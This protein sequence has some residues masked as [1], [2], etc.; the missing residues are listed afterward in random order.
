[1]TFMH[2]TALPL[3][4]RSSSYTVRRISDWVRRREALGNVRIAMAEQQVEPQAP[5]VEQKDIYMTPDKYAGYLRNRFRTRIQHQHLKEHFDDAVGFRFNALVLGVDKSIK[6]Q[7]EEG[8]ESPTWP[9]NQ[10][11]FIPLKKAGLFVTIPA[12]EESNV[13]VLP[14]IEKLEADGTRSPL[15]Y[16]DNTAMAVLKYINEL[17][18][19]VPHSSLYGEIITD[20][21]EI[22]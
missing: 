3:M 22:I 5:Q 4:D 10:N 21:K 12:T 20:P 15:N 17:Q 8:I 9:V 14:V 6:Q 18:L 1:M 2:E 16:N 13:D 7:K 11:Y 19:G